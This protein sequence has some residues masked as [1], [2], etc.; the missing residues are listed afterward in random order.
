[1]NEE[2]RPFMSEV[3][4]AAAKKFNIPKERILGATRRPEV[5]HA[6]HVAMWIARHD[7]CESYPAIGRYF[8]RDH[9][10]VIKAVRAIDESPS[11]AVVAEDIKAVRAAI[12][13]H[14][15]AGESLECA[16]C[17]GLRRT[18]ERLRAELAECYAEMDLRR[19]A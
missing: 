19:T 1:V 11:A 16:G 6:R 17:A 9:S 18:V 8:G 4:R 3:V 10:G 7:C 15:S 13:A 12:Q 14:L 5:V 2:R